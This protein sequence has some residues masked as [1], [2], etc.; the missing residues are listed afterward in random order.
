DMENIDLIKLI[1]IIPKDNRYQ[2]K[3][4]EMVAETLGLFPFKAGMMDDYIY[5]IKIYDDIKLEH[6]D[7][8]YIKAMLIAYPENYIENYTL[9]IRPHVCMS[10][11]YDKCI[12]RIIPINL[13]KSNDIS[14]NIK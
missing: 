14:D 5:V 13:I 3:L 10:F 1:N 9:I 7:Y 11:T 12:H 8:K 4:Q 6:P 2:N